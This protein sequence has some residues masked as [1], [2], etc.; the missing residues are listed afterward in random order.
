MR[1]RLNVLA[2]P[3]VLAASLAAP[4]AAPMAAHAQDIT[5]KETGSTLILRVFQAWAQKYA[6]GHAGVTI[7]TEG[8]GSEHGVA[9]AIDGSAQI[10]TSDAFLSNEQASRYPGVLTIAMAISAQTIDYNLPGE[11]RAL[12]LDGP[13]LAEIYRGKIRFWDDKA[14]AG[15]NP[16]VALPHHAIIPVHRADGSGDTFVFTQYLSFTTESETPA[17]FFAPSH[18]WSE[19]PGFGTTIDWPVVDG[20]QAATGNAGMVDVLGKT[21]YSIGYVGVSFEDQARAAGLGTAMV[22]G[23][24]G[25]F[26]LPTPDTESAA[27]A[28][29]TPRTPAD[30][31]LSL[32]NAPGANCY[33]LI[34]YEYAMVRARQKDPATASALRRFLLWATVPDETTQQILAASHF[35][36]LPPHIWAKTYD[37]IEK[38]Q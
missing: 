18:S 22:R 19:S 33:P 20:A 32:I 38:I 6:S 23:Y 2:L 24:S 9:A 36:P 5:L 31:R 13:V 10:G 3:V 37:Q 14:L 16:G 25:Q 4:L 11:M 30:E 21:P 17:G 34:N 15:L 12:K 26:L 28:S 35:I 27:A 1:D 8:T 7:T 29:L